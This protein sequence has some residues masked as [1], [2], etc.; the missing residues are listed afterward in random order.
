MAGKTT[1]TYPIKYIN[2]VNKCI[3]FAKN[4]EEEKKFKDN[5]DYTL[6]TE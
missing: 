6:S 3:Y 5:S 2:T 1:K 4:A